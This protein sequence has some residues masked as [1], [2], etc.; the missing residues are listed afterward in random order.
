[1]GFVTVLMVMLGLMAS[2]SASAQTFLNT[3]QAELLLTTEI[4]QLQ[5]TQ[6]QTMKTGTPAEQHQLQMKQ[7][8]HQMIL[9][10][11]GAGMGVQEAMNA[12]L[13]HPRL[14]V[15]NTS[16]VALL[17]RNDHTYWLQYY[18]DLLSN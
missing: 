3:E 2:G 4:K 13:N 1:M 8:L 15:R 10:N 5:L 9:N 18:T 11:L 7:L 16:G 6:D 12:A 14:Q 17:S